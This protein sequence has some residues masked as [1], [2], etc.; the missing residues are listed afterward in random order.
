[1]LQL[2]RAIG[3]QIQKDI[4]P[5]VGNKNE[6]RLDTLAENAASKIFQNSGLSMI[7][8]SEESGVTR[9]GNNPQYICQ[10]DPL[11]G[12]YNAAN[13]IPAY[14][15]SIA[16]SRFKENPTLEDIEFAFI[17]NLVNGAEFKAYKR[18]NR[19]RDNKDIINQVNNSRITFGTYCAYLYGSDL[20]KLSPLL[21]KFRRIRSLG[22]ISL[23]LC[24]VANNIYDGLIDLRGSVRNV[25][26]A[27][28]KLLIEEAGG[29]ITRTNGATL[30]VGIEKINNLSFIASG[31]Q[32]MHDK[33]ITILDERK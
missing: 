6:K 16:F 14:S 7:V 3:E 20:E 13:G 29:K 26:I 31:N 10:L 15:F 32:N 30:D 4:S 22:C 25:D 11:D 19:K 27:A 21:K 9:Y 23:E 8:V 12:T 5:L 17:K 1:M 18:K 24:F 2:S 28:G 33:L